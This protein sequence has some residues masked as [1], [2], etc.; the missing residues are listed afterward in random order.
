MTFHES[1]ASAHTARDQRVGR[2]SV[3]ALL[4]AL[5]A[6]TGCGADGDGDR[7]TDR[8]PPPTV[9]TPD[10]VVYETSEYAIRGPDV[11]P[12]GTTTITAKNVGAET[13]HLVFA[14]LEPGQTE[15]DFNLAFAAL[16]PAGV[17]T[18]LG[19]PSGVSPGS[20]VSATIPLSAGDYVVACFV[21]GHDG[22]SHFLKGMTGT[23]TVVPSD[24]HLRLPASDR[25]VRLGEYTF[26]HGGDELAGFAG[27]G[28]L[29]V[30][31]DGTEIHELTIVRIR[32]DATTED[33][34]ATASLPMGAPRPVPMPYQ[35][36][37][38]ISFLSQGESGWIDLDALS[39]TPGRYAL[40]CFIPSPSDRTAHAAKGMVHEFTVP[41]SP[42]PGS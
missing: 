8:P 16:D 14:R 23:L 35:G 12:A 37:G 13:H 31:N 42:T 2:V 4:M 26:G 41:A 33:V 6:A 3:V 10:E 22:M 40:V 39:L 24:A 18:L 19:G 1:R 11:L 32:D 29:T 15:A 27:N 5:L 20:S 34:I 21:P 17:A 25:T 9:E 7:G 38:G 28:T 30:T 36:V